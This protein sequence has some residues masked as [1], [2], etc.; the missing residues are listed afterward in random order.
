MGI[1]KKGINR[2][3]ASYSDMGIAARM[4]TWMYQ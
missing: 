2:E 4:V 1:H 3:K